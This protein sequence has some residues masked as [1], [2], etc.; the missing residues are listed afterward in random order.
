[1]TFIVK[2]I[3]RLIHISSYGIFCALLFNEYIFT[4]P[5]IQISKIF[6]ISLGLA[7]SISGIINLIILI[8]ENNFVKDK[9]YNFWK[10][11]LYL[12]FIGFLFLTPLFDKLLYSDENPKIKTFSRGLFF[13]FALVLSPLARFYR[14]KYLIKGNNKIK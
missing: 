11:L 3:F 10:L 13:L 1:M 7:L 2:Y 12:K 9:K 4:T 14:E 6:Y 8:K 5:N